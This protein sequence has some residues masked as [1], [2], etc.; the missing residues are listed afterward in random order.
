MRHFHVVLESLY[1]AYR[2]LIPCGL[3]VVVQQQG[4]SGRISARM[5]AIESTQVE[6][7]QQ[8]SEFLQSSNQ[9]Q[10]VLNNLSTMFS[11]MME[12]IGNPV[13]VCETQSPTTQNTNSQMPSL[14][15][16][17]NSVAGSAGDPPPD[18]KRLKMNMNE[19]L[20]DVA[21]LKGKSIMQDEENHKG[22]AIEDGSL[23][24]GNVVA[25]MGDCSLRA[26]GN[27]E[28]SEQNMWRGRKR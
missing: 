9:N 15:R 17:L 22:G 3:F 19:D 27:G 2:V 18:P 4:V 16:M 8:M 23:G 13:P 20:S 24:V 7:R 12:K 10:L 11:I 28:G 14:D 5:S 26:P 1:E 25:P 6:F 21:K